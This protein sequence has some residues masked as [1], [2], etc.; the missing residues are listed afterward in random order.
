MFVKQAS[1]GVFKFIKVQDLTT[2]DQAM[3]VDKN[4]VGI[5]SI[6][7]FTDLSAP[8]EVVNMNVEDCDVYFV[9]GILFHNGGGK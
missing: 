4:L 1:S 9:D 5:T 3:D 8:F 6:E 2:N 7:I